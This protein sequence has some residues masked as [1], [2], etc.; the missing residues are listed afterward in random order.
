M[1]VDDPVN[2]TGRAGKIIEFFGVTLIWC[3]QWQGPSRVAP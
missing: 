3:A 2:T 1:M